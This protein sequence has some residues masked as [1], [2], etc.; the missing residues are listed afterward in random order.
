MTGIAPPRPWTQCPLFLL[1]E[2]PALSAPE[3]LGFFPEQSYVEEN[4]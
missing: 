1:G 3:V 4:L 2:N